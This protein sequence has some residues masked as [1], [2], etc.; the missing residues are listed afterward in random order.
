ML[1]LCR[2]AVGRRLAAWHDFARATRRARRRL[3]R[4]CERPRRQV[5]RFCNIK[6]RQTLVSLTACMMASI[7]ARPLDELNMKSPVAV[8][9]SRAWFLLGER[10]RLSVLLRLH[11]LVLVR[12]AP[13]VPGG[14]PLEGA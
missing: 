10:Y 6:T 8:N 14:L 9:A 13:L 12:P 3:R 1:V 7:L 4:A 11:A 5:W 2:S